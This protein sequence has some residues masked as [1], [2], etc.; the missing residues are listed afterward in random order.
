VEGSKRLDPGEGNKKNKKNKKE[1]KKREKEKN[2]E[3]QTLPAELTPHL[4]PNVV[5][6]EGAFGIV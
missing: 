4:D 6:G 5:L 1:K 2:Q 3:D